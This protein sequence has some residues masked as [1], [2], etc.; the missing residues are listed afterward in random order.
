VIWLFLAC[1]VIF[2]AGWLTRRWMA[3]RILRTPGVQ[4]SHGRR[5]WARDIDVRWDRW[6]KLLLM[7]QLGSV[8]LSTEVTDGKRLA[9][10]VR[11]LNPPGSITL[12]GRTEIG[13]LVKDDTRET[14]AFFLALGELPS[15][16]QLGF[17]DVSL[18]DTEFAE[19][20]RQYPNLESLLFWRTNYTGDK[21][22]PLAKLQQCGVV[23]S[24]FT[25]AALAA[26]LRCPELQDLALRWT[27]VTVVGVQQVPQARP[28][29]LVSFA[30][31][32]QNL[33]DAECAELEALLLK[34]QL[35]AE[36]RGDINTEGDERWHADTP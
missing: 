27:D 32:N 29:S 28:K 21:F 12:R 36:I 2:S 17:F 34:D 3:L 16:K 26:V 7:R 24:P 20:V 23:D 25:D 30:Y 31:W 35:R 8:E 6:D 18:T 33:T 10:A 13:P 9:W 1:W 5:P 4:W 15:V 22:P 14:Q 11:A 19:V